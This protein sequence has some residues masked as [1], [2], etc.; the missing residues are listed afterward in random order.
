M[1]A[2]RGLAALAVVGLAT[3]CSSRQTG[4]PKS[5]H[6]RVEQQMGPATVTSEY[7]RPVARG[8]T[9]FGGIVPFGRPWD[10]GADA[11]S[12]ISFSRDVEVEGHALPSGTYSIWAI[13]RRDVWTFILSRAAHVFHEPY[14]EGQDALRVSV[15]PVA[16]SH[17]ETLAYYFPLVDADSATLHLHWGL[18]VVPIHL[19]AR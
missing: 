14:P 12:T 9:I 3:G 1:R 19:R 8:R 2:R 15:T 13:P 18:T 7:N 16:A 6:A 17:V 4:I 10:P 5:H 11:A